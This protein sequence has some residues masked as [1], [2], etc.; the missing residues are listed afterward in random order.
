MDKEI[1]DVI[2]VGGGP[3]GLTT[4]IYTTREGLNT[5][6][7]EKNLCGGIASSTEWVENYPGFPE[8]ISGMDLMQK[9]KEQSIKFGAKIEEFKEVKKIVPNKDILVQTE[10]EEYIGRTLVIASGSLPK[11]LNVEGE[12]RFFG[13]GVSF[14]ATCDG[15]LFKGKD[16]AVIGCGNSGLQ[17]GLVLSNY[18]RKIYFIEFM[19]YMNAEKI[20]QDRVRSLTNS[21]IFLNN[22]VI[23]INGQDRVS[24]ITIED[25]DNLQKKEIKVDGVFI[26]VGFLPATDIV[27][28]IVELDKWGYIKTDEDMRTSVENIFAIGD[29]RSKKVRQL[30][31]ASGEGTIAAIAIREYLRNR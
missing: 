11:K 16:V 28:G 30:T 7:I 19:P 15:P 18:V 13:R 21:S 23:S 27:K 17:E 6:I 20:L 2:I 14:C 4:A 26:Y 24:S 5:L 10:R 12:D 29:V 31:V 9:F 22:K 8:G 25:R 1:F 3:A